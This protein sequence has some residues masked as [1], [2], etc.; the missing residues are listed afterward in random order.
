MEKKRKHEEAQ[1]L[2]W[3]FFWKHLYTWKKSQPI[4][5]VLIFTSPKW[6]FSI[7]TQRETQESRS[8]WLNC[9]LSDCVRQRR[10]VSTNR[11]RGTSVFSEVSEMLRLESALRPPG[12]YCHTHTHTMQ[13]SSA[14]EAALSNIPCWLFLENLKASTCWLMINIS[15]GWI[16]EDSSLEVP[17][18]SHHIQ[19]KSTST[20][21]SSSTPQSQQWKGWKWQCLSSFVNYSFFTSNSKIDNR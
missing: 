16:C 18:V 6:S 19:R 20:S 3:C 9:C 13:A 15:R 21:S 1:N 10:L 2:F 7:P 5:A 11:P 12:S 14:A 4:D 17:P 8:S